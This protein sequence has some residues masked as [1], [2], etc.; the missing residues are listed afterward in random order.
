[1]NSSDEEIFIE[2]AE[3]SKADQSISIVITIAG[4]FIIILNM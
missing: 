1:M 4:V 2:T 3:E